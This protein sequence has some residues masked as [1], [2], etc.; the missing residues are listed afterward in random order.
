M[1]A[2]RRAVARLVT[3]ALPLAIGCGGG[4]AA[5]GAEPAPAPQPARVVASSRPFHWSGA[6]ARGH[7]F[8]VRTLSGSIRAV[9]AVG[10]VA[11]V[12]AQIRGGRADAVMTIRVAEDDQ[13][14]QVRAEWPRDARDHGCGNDEGAT[15]RDVAVDFV[16]HVPEGVKLA[17]HSV[18]GSI[19][20]DGVRGP[21]EVRTVN[22]AIDLRGVTQARA[23]AVNGGI[24]VAFAARAW[25]DDV[26]LATVNGAIDV[27]LPASAAADVRAHS[28]NG[29]VRV[30]FPIDGTIGPHLANG[31]IGH[32]GRELRLRT[33]SGPIHVAKAS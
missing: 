11:D 16:V 32:G 15:A 20:G 24:Q 10:D 13:G 3:L 23:R 33:I 28:V 26:E 22:G 5:G 9:P 8:D 18:N 1:N 17:A 27:S 25:E 2:S 6:I 29:D 19:V 4:R 31:S 30:D 7:V 12:E 21:V 14:V